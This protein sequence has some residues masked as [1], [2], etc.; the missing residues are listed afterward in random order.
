VQYYERQ[1]VKSD[2]DIVVLIRED[3]FEKVL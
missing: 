3:F 2:C 1:F